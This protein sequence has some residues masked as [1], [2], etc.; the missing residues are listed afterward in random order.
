[1]RTTYYEELSALSA[2]VGEMCGLA[3][4][5]MER[6]THALLGADLSVAEQVIADHERIVAMSKRTEASALKPVSYT[7]LTLP[8]K[9]IV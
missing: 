2:Q 4:D 6:A 7:H 5:A 3:A 8:T 9:R 1:M